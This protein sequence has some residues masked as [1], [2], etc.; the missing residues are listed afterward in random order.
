MNLQSNSTLGKDG[1]GTSLDEFK[2]QVRGIK[3][4]SVASWV[5]V[6]EVPG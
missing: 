6:N 1:R 4:R 3:P 5:N 2:L